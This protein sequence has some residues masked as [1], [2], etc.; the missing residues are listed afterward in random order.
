MGLRRINRRVSERVYPRHERIGWTRSH[1]EPLRPGVVVDAS[2]S[3]IA[4]D[5]EAGSA[6]GHGEAIRVLSRRGRVPR[7]GRVVRI[8]DLDRQHVRVACR[9]I[10]SGH[11]ASSRPQT[12]RPFRAMPSR[13]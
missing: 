3:G 5:V 8:S 1:G 13:P 9:W 7:R 6:P 2:A 10:S 4:M 11:E 12:S